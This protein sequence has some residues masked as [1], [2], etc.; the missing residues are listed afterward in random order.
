[1]IEKYLDKKYELQSSENFDNFM[2]ALG[3]FFL[4]S[5]LIHSVHFISIQLNS[6]QFHCDDL[7]V[8]L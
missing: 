5:I 2:Q 7:S 8:Y 6:T 3:K 1:M 4:V